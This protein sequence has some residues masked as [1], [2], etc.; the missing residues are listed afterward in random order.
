MRY[1]IFVSVFCAALLTAKAE[2]GREVIDAKICLGLRSTFSGAIFSSHIRYEFD[3]L[4]ADVKDVYALEKFA[5]FPVHQKRGAE[6]VLFDKMVGAMASLGLFVDAASAET[7]DI[8]ILTDRPGVHSDYCLQTVEPM[9][10]FKN[11]NTFKVTMNCLNSGIREF[12][13]VRNEHDF[14]RQFEEGSFDKLT[15][16]GNDPSWWRER[17]RRPVR[18]VYAFRK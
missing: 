15:F 6:V 7:R 2:A 11:G 4:G 8:V 9:S 18:T 13:G 14:D 5:L 12:S 3:C 1:A 16:F 17:A 10:D